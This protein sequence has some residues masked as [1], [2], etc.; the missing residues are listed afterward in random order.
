MLLLFVKTY[1]AIQKL[2]T[3]I[4]DQNI[5]SCCSSLEN[6]R[7]WA[8]SLI[9]FLPFLYSP[10]SF[11]LSPFPFL[12]LFPYIENQNEL[13]M[14]KNKKIILGFITCLP[15]IFFIWYFI[16]I[17][18]FIGDIH[19][20]EQT[21][22]FQG[23]TEPMG[24]MANL[25]LPILLAVVITLGLLVFYLVDIHT[26]NHKLRTEKNGKLIWTLVVLLAG[27]LGMIVYFFIEVMPRKELPPVPTQDQE[28]V[29][30]N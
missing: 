17:F 4:K 15:I 26:K 13:I 27:N 7:R 9:T 16:A 29:W 12:L 1:P 6:F 5:K 19:N 28:T 30:N 20:M 2:S 23:P 3:S 8:F 14:S 10:S 18:A 22:N 24:I 25:L 11:L 21:G